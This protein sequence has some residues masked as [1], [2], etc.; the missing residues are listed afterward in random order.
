MLVAVVRYT[1]R[2]LSL[3]PLGPDT[4]LVAAR[5]GEVNAPPA[6]ELVWSLY[7]LAASCLDRF[8]ARFKIV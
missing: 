7:D 8:D 4:Q 5:V 1:G 6:W 2:T 3:L